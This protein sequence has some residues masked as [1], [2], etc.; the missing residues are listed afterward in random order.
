MHSPNAATAGELH[1]SFAAKDAAQ[2]DKERVDGILIAVKSAAQDK[3]IPDEKNELEPCSLN[4]ALDGNP[5]SIKA[6]KRTA[7]LQRSPSSL[8]ERRGVW[9]EGRRGPCPNIYR[10]SALRL[11][12]HTEDAATPFGRDDSSSAG[13]RARFHLSYL[14]SLVCFQNPEIR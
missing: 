7:E 13:P 3:S 9:G 8:T 14:L 6:S 5:F 1:R 2:D 4:L 10:R 12:P 11:V